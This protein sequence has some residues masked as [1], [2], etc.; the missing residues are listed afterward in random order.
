MEQNNY[1]GALQ[2]PIGS[3]YNA[4]S[5]ATEVIN[6]INLKGK[7][8]IVTG[9]NAGIDLETTKVLA[10]AGATVIVAARD[11]EKAKKNLKGV[12]NVELEPLDLIHPSSIDDFANKFL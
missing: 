11:I 6:G 1:Q 12:G 10:Q 8:A 9:G 5:T 7:I 2:K 4:A 3:G